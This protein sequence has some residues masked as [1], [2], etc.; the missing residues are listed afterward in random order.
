M[1]PS[2]KQEAREKERNQLHQVT[3][4]YNTLVRGVERCWGLVEKE[5]IRQLDD[6]DPVSLFIYNQSLTL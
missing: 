4:K 1:K 3:A 5:I 6:A 2:K